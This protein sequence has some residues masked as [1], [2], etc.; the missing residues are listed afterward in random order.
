MRAER[1]SRDPWPQRADPMSREELFLSQLPVIERVIAWVCSRRGLR[2]ADA[3][4]FG[5]AS[6]ARLIENDYEILGRF[7][8]RSSLATYLT[9]VVSRLYLDFQVQ[10]FGKWRPSAE[11]RRRGPVA[12]RLEQL[13]LRDG[14][15]FDEAC[16]VIQTNP[17]VLETRDALYEISMALPNRP[18]RE[19]RGGDPEPATDSS[20][21]ERA[22][23]QALA[24]RTFSIIS[25]SLAALP[26]RDRLF[27]RLHL[28]SGFTV[29]EAAR[30]LGLE[31]KPLY[32]RKEDVLKRLRADLESAG[33]GP[34]AAHELLTT[35]DWEVALQVE[36]PPLKEGPENVVASPSL[37][38]GRA[39]RV[40][41][42]P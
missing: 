15:S 27:L 19:A 11:A 32:R 14:L 40:G 9:A 29:A 3:E 10:R 12:V 5:S 42:E 34:D 1:G 37:G 31:Q 26:P 24:E 23:R 18:R 35:L 8:G 20:P 28:E 38:K 4:D 22:E 36:A 6:K 41:G 7:E 21:A 16:G 25:G 33:I 2:G 17:R 13:L 30:S 39:A